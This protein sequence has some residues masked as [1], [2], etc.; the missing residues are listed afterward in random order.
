MPRGKTLKM[1]ATQTPLPLE[2]TYKLYD[3]LLDNGNI[4][5]KLG[6]RHRPKKGQ[7]KRFIGYIDSS[8]PA[9]DQYSYISSL[10][11]KQGTTTY[12]LEHN[13]E[14]YDLVMTGVNTVVIKKS[15]REPILVFKQPAE[16][17]KAG[18]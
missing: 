9:D 16:L 8:K 18:I 14:I 7:A 2:G 5:L 10:Y 6:L 1:V 17:E 13:K 4:K 12:Y 11:S 3:D 15:K